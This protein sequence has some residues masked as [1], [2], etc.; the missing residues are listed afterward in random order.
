M[1]VA[2]PASFAWYALPTS[3]RGG[4]ADDVSALRTEITELRQSPSGAP[5]EPAGR[6]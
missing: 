4:E 2:A 1:I 3:H 5:N 6:D